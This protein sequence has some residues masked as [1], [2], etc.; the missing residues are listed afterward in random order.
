MD[1]V[2]QMLDPITKNLVYQFYNFLFCG[3]FIGLLSGKKNRILRFERFISACSEPRD[4]LVL[5]VAYLPYQILVWRY[6]P[7]LVMGTCPAFRTCF[8]HSLVP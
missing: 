6:D 7:Q 1:G 8:C 5:L 2:I 4:D 3:I